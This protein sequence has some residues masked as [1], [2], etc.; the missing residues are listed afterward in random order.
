VGGKCQCSTKLRPHAGPLWCLAPRLHHVSRN[1]LNSC[2]K[3]WRQTQA[4]AGSRRTLA[5]PH[6]LKIPRRSSPKGAT[7]EPETDRPRPLLRPTAP[8]LRPVLYEHRSDRPRFRRGQH[9]AP[10]EDPGSFI[11]PLTRRSF[12]PRR[13]A[14]GQRFSPIR[15]L[16][17]SA[18]SPQSPPHSGAPAPRG[19]WRWDSVP[20]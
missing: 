20:R 1:A 3:T 17:T 18:A 7:D 9:Q 15:F 4:N 16:V 14:D 5:C 6:S 11:P 19:G 10:A 2:K 12:N 8:P 13:A